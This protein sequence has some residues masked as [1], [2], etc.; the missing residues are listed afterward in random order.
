ML[1]SLDKL[2]EFRNTPDFGYWADEITELADGIERE[3]AERYMPLP[4]DADGVPIRDGDK[5]KIPNAGGGEYGVF[6]VARDYWVD[7]DGFTH[8][9]MQTVH[10]K[11]RTLE[12]VLSDVWKEALDYAKSDMWRSPDEVFS[13]RANEIREL[14]GRDE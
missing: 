5:V 11:P 7:V 14:M 9:P 3:V 13:E 1:D 10:A 2:R 4:V 8:K 6:A 12:D